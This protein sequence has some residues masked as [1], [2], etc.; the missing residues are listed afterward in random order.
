[1]SYDHQEIGDFA[2]ERD[3]QDWA[4]RNGI[5]VRDLHLRAVA[6]ARRDPERAPVGARGFCNQRPLLWPPDR[7][8]LKTRRSPMKLKYLLFA[9]LPS[10]CPAL[11]AAPAGS[12]L[13]ATAIEPAV[14]IGYGG[15]AQELQRVADALT[16]E[17]GSK[18][19]ANTREAV[20]AMKARIK[21]MKRPSPAD[22]PLPC[23]DCPEKAAAPRPDS[24]SQ[25]RNH[26]CIT[27]VE[28][29]ILA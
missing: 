8:F 10:A 26:D 11:A 21:A 15:R 29:A 18:S 14:T 27:C 20:E 6:R 16:A 28:E 17:M 24:A 9:C 4:E 2:N 19:G 5:D 23:E 3:A 25:V 1:M 13:G 7:L 22:A 12:G